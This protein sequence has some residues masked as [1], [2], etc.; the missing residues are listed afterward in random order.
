ME[1]LVSE[2]IIYWFNQFVHDKPNKVVL[3]KDTYKLL[4]K[5][6][7][8][9]IRKSDEHCI[10]YSVS[11]LKVADNYII[12]ILVDNLNPAFKP[13]TKDSFLLL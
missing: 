2:S 4:V 12:D 11:S 9:P 8:P 10:D 6:Y 1:Y 13:V 5:E 7:F 3:S